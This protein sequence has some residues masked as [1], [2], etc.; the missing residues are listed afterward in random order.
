MD[1]L[2]MDILA[3]L[4]LPISIIGHI[5]RWTRPRLLLAQGLT[6]LLVAAVE[7][8]AGEPDGEAEDQGVDDD[9]HG[10][11]EAGNQ[12]GGHRYDRQHGHRCPRGDAEAL[13]VQPPAG[14]RQWQAGRGD[15]EQ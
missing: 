4:L 11:K 12:G 10:A 5:S 13:A 15:H 7:E 3:R 14:E 9:G 8:E 6:G 2:A 1:I